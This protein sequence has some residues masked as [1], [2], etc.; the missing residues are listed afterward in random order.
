MKTPFSVT[1]KVIPDRLK[2]PHSKAFEAWAVS[3][4]E[5]QPAI[6]E[7]DMLPK[8]DSPLDGEVFHPPRGKHG[9]S[10]YSFCHAFGALRAGCGIRVV[11]INRRSH[12]PG[13]DR[14]YGYG[15]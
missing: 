2:E 11:K 7:L 15:S 6:T 13:S 5:A 8:D 14:A 10:S 3:F 1:T 12:I 9:A 4:C